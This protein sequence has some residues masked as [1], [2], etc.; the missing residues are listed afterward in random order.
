MNC[1]IILYILGDL[2]DEDTILAWLTSQE[3]FEIKDEI[4][5]VN[6]KMLEKLLDEN[7]F[8]AVYFCKYQHNIG[9]KND[10]HCI[11]FNFSCV[12]FFYVLPI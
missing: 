11:T 8:V 10:E 3:I 6:K 2:L 1:A 7:D 5:E 9:F 12:I 4:E